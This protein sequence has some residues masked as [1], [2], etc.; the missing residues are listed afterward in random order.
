LSRQHAAAL[1]TRAESEFSICVI[2]GMVSWDIESGMETSGRIA[3][4]Y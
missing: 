4:A 2:A 1:S 3:P